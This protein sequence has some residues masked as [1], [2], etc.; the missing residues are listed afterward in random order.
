MG[1]SDCVQSNR[2][3]TT[4]SRR[5]FLGLLSIPATVLGFSRGATGSTEPSRS[6]HATERETVA[7]KTQSPIP[8]YPDDPFVQPAFGMQYIK[9]WE[10]HGWKDVGRQQVQESVLGLHPD[11]L[12]FDQLL[13][14]DDGELDRSFP[15]G[16]H[17]DQLALAQE[18]EL[19]ST[20]G[21]NVHIVSDEE[22]AN[23]RYGPI[24][25][26]SAWEFPDGTAVSSPRDILAET[27]DGESQQTAYE[28]E[29]LGT[30]SVFAPGGL[31]LMTN[32]TIR[33]LE[34]GYSGFFVDG[35]GVF[36][37][38]GLDFSRWA[39]AAFRS[40]LSSL[41]D[42]RLSAL[43]IE[44]PQSFEIREYLQANRLTPD[45]DTDPREDPV[46]REYL[47]HQHLGIDSWFEQYRD[48]IAEVFPERMENGEI[49]LYANQFTGNLH[50][51]QAPNIY[52]SDSMDAMYTELFP[53]VNPAVGVNYKIMQS[54]GNFSKPVIGKGTL[55]AAGQEELG[56]IDPTTSNAMLQRFQAAEAFACGARFQ[57]PLTPR[58]GHNEE[59]SITNWVAGDGTVP[60]K[61]TTF[62][63]FLWSHE[64]FFT[65]T[66][67]AGDVA[68]LWSLPTQIWRREATWD[69]GEDGESRPVDSFTG[70]GSILREAG[71]TF[72][73]LTFGHPR[74][75]DD[76]V[77]LSKLE[78]YDVVILAGV[79][80][81]SDGQVA[82]L[83]SYL[84]NGGELI[85]ADSVPDRDAMFN[86]R[87]DVQPIF[88][89][90]TATV[91]DGTPG[92]D[93]ESRGESDGTL[94]NALAESSVEP[95]RQTDHSAVAV[96][97]HTQTDPDRQLIHLVN[98]DYDPDSDS[99]STASN[100]NLGLP[101][102]DATQTVAQLYR[103]QGQVDLEVTENGGQ[104]TVE[105]P[106]VV[107]WGV[108]VLTT[109]ENNFT[110]GTAETAREKIAEAR[111][112]IPVAEEAVI[113]DPEKL[114]IAKSKLDAAAIALENN[115]YA[116]ASE[117]A[118]EASALLQQL[119]PEPTATETQSTEQTSEGDT[120]TPAS[121]P[122]SSTETAAPG[123][124]IVSGIV[125]VGLAGWKL[126]KGSEES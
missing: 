21:M 107:E 66:E 28:F 29:T 34:S 40:H 44:S 111:E 103:P 108:V 123:L 20:S 7:Q 93:K 116:Q 82:A 1:D 67:P 62:A 86:P 5:G 32:G 37:L 69:I 57:L 106:E 89:R 118:D 102:V 115:G 23:S 54:V 22:T 72:D 4:R 99:F 8:P 48:E 18:L 9:G 46:F 105:L 42:D 6:S 59:E 109:D 14:Y 39:Q 31:E 83:N 92:L 78:E 114:I 52:I 36:R 50:N 27:Y 85:C 63:N 119:I 81:V 17:T 95:V 74:L 25:T 77:Q 104:P 97:S 100:V 13:K 122:T 110:Q 53:T 49:S 45:D 19:P 33:Q 15:G 117:A 76:S 65:E 38:H 96:H 79:N 10:N 124:S 61:L 101:A 68:L 41:S 113:G 73:V 3:D 35:V 24:A 16:S 30:P 55:S 11:V 2:F 98:Y 64:R 26:E 12:A 126:L 60:E 56:G 80:S 51:P 120:G 84:D 43:G 71:Y 90:D 88:D 70:T 94:L 125:A 91:V 87:S 75:W 112:Q 47:L 58:M 121:T